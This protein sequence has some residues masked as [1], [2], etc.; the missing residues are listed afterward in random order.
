MQTPQ[1]ALHSSGIEPDLVIS[2][3]AITLA[4]VLL[5]KASPC[6]IRFKFTLLLKWVQNEFNSIQFICS[7]CHRRTTKLRLEHPIKCKPINNKYPLNPSVN[8]NPVWLQYNMRQFLL[9][10]DGVK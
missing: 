10:H 3:S 9:Q 6:A 5:S 4:I 1:K 2:C 7:H 8:I